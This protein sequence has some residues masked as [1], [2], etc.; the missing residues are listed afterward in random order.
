MSIAPVQL[1]LNAND[2]TFN[3][4]ITLEFESGSRGS[5][6]G[7]AVILNGEVYFRITISRFLRTYTST[8][9]IFLIIFIWIG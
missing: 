9:E 7:S 1:S 6:P 4:V 3:L 5:S 2:I 8:I